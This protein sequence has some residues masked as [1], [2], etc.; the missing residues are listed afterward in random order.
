VKTK[1]TKNIFPAPLTGIIVPMVTP[2]KNQDTLDLPGLERLI[3]HIL[4]GGVQGLFILGTTGEGPSLSRQLQYD[5]I[6]RVCAQV[7]TRVPVLVGISNT[8]F[9][10]SVNICHKA[11]AAGAMAVVLAPPFYFSSEQP[12]LL[13]YLENIMSEIS[14]P[15]FLYNFNSLLSFEPKIV[16]AA[17]SIKGIVGLKDSSANMVYFHQVQMLFKDKPDFSLLVGPEELLGEAV[18]L[19]AHGGVCGGANLDPS[20]YVQLYNAAASKD[21]ATVTVL[22]DR[23]MKISTTIYSVGRYNSSYLRGLKCA[24]SCMGLCNDFLAEPFHRFSKKEH[25]QI[26]KHVQALELIPNKANRALTSNQRI[27]T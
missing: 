18:L 19:G 13:E 16:L 25:D 27:V 22:H 12:E 23:V 11:Q 14:L 20:L 6:E 15:L 8:S 26:H 17:A 10:E 7:A 21:M 2:L 3:E 9:V 5:F 4:N 1:I 24:L